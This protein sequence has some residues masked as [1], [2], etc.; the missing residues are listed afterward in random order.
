MDR[1][2]IIFGFKLGYANGSV[3]ARADGRS[4][5]ADTRGLNRPRDRLSG[6]QGMNAARGLLAFSHSIDHLPAAVGAVPAG[7]DSR[8]IRSAAVRVSRHD[9]VRIQFAVREKLFQQASLLLLADGFDDHVKGF[10]K[11]RSWQNTPLAGRGRGSGELD[12]SDMT[13]A[14]RENLKRDHIEKKARPV[15]PGQCL[16]ELVGGHIGLRA[17]IKDDGVAGPEP[18]GLSY[19][20]NRGIAAANNR[21]PLADRHRVQRLFVYRLDEIQGLHHLRQFLARNSQF[22]AAA[23]AYADK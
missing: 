4:F 11:F 10:D 17:A 22:R 1:S 9:S 18:P 23:Q 16:F 19:G 14:I 15:A 6:E 5:H 7:E 12:A 8:Q 21:D 20:I 2:A 3:K 13:R